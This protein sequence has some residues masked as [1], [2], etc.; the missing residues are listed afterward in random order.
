MFTTRH[1]DRRRFLYEW[2]ALGVT[3]VVI[4]TMF[5][6]VTVPE[7]GSVHAPVFLTVPS[8]KLHG[9][10]PVH[11]TVVAADGRE[12]VKVSGTFIAPVPGTAK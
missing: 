5:A 8:A 1:S 11:A 6:E 10:F 3:L 4:G 2:M 12:A 9:S 7:L